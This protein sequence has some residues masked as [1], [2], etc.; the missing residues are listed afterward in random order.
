MATISFIQDVIIKDEE[1]ITEIK[2]AMNSDNKAF[3]DIKH[4]I[5]NKREKNFIKKWIEESYNVR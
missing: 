4:S 5:D 3:E 1:K 2:I